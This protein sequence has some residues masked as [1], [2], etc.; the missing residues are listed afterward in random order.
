MRVIGVRT[1]HQAFD[2][3]S[4]TIDN[5]NDPALVLLGHKKTF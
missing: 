1:T 4:L 3:V 5:F 2:G